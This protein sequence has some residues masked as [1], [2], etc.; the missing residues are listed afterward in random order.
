MTSFLAMQDRGTE[1]PEMNVIKRDGNDAML[2]FRDRMG[3]RNARIS[4]RCALGDTAIYGLSSVVGRINDRIGS[5][6]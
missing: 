6:S 3:E 2:R 1:R 4:N 5:L